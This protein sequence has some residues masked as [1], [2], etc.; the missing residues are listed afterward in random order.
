[1]HQR[2]MIQTPRSPRS[3]F[4]DLPVIPEDESCEETIL[5]LESGNGCQQSA[6]FLQEARRQEG[7]CDL[8]HSP[9]LDKLA[10]IH[11]SNMANLGCVFH[12]V[13]SVLDL[14]EH[15]DSDC[16]GENIQRGDS[17]SLMHRETMTSVDSINRSNILS[18]HFD[19]FGCGVA[20]GRDG[21]VYSCQLFR[22][23]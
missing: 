7:L 5:H 18:E 9:D 22:K 1:M 2:T 11:A 17:I 3:V 15:L 8:L 12:S 19:E 10:Q 4:R 16:V 21:K 6:Y 14:Q 13:A 23:L 20:I